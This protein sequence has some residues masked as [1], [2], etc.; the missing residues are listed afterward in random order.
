MARSVCSSKLPFTFSERLT[1]GWSRVFRW[2]VSLS[3]AVKPSLP[4]RAIGLAAV[5]CLTWSAAQAQTFSTLYSFKA[6]LNAGNISAGLTPGSNGVFYGASNTGGKYGNG[7]LFYL[8]PPATSGGAWTLHVFHAFSTD[9]GPGPVSDLTLDSAGAIY[10]ASYPP[11]NFG[12]IFRITPPAGSGPWVEDILY[13]FPGGLMGAV[14]VG[15][16]VFDAVGNLFGVT[17]QGG[18]YGNGVVY[19][20]SPPTVA[21]SPWTE[22]VLH[23]FQ[24]N[25]DGAN[26]VTLDHDLS[27]PLFGVCANG[28]LSNAGTVFRLFPPSPT[29][30]G[31]SFKVLYTFSGAADGAHPSGLKIYHGVKYGTTTSGG[32]YG[33]GTA[34][35]IVYAGGIFTTSTIYSF[36]ANTGDGFSP[37][38]N[39]VAD[40]ALNLYGITSG[41]GTGSAGTAYRLTPPLNA[42]DPF[43]ETLLHTFNAATD[44][45]APLGRLVLDGNG[46]LYGT[47]SLG[48]G[49][50]ANSSAVFEISPE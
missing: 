24:G 36:G 44:G 46:N 25:W 34:F 14:P 47:T 28:G 13:S 30:P 16:L 7:R 18:Q 12:N 11:T 20:L 39:L 23:S 2:R 31:W 29:N 5:Y 17:S 43:T 22:T 19:E 26:P 27:G 6:P 21:G 45:A 15:D 50:S 40:A 37:Q 41:G 49:Q 1:L 4:V 35:H 3:A 42:G 9:E 38:G 32:Q 10:G 33:Q 8:A 48:I